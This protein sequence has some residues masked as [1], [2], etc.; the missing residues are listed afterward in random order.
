MSHLACDVFIIFKIYVSEFKAY[1]HAAIKGGL[2]DRC[3]GH[4]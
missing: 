3:F 4:S 1:R 2:N